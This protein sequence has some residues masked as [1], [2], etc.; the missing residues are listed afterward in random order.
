MSLILNSEV[1]GSDN[2]QDM[3][4][5]H[6]LFGSISNWRTISRSLS[7]HYRV[8]SLDLR[9]HGDSP[10]SDE[11]SY[12]DMAGDIALYIQQHNLNMPHI[13]GHSMGG[14]T[15]MVL[16]QHFNI[17]TGNVFIIDIAPISYAH[18]HDY[19]LSALQTLDLTPLQSRKEADGLLAERIES[20]G[21]RQFL[22]QNLKRTEQGFSW[23]IN[24]EAVSRNKAS[25]FSY[26]ESSPSQHPVL[27]IRGAHSDYV[28]PENHQEIQ[29]HFPRSNIETIS[30]AGHWLHAEQ[31]K[32]LLSMLRQ[33][34]G[35]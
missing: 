24:L 1:T 17:V 13:L 8:H 3:I 28:L 20:L 14:K 2:V 32:A 10:W 23:R 21:I 16:L 31:P 25:I 5:I 26:P 33:Y 19:L 29:Q 4:I 11:M 6:G 35:E 27:F 22:L 12:L 15:A 7:D 30:S 34:L 9:N 18:D